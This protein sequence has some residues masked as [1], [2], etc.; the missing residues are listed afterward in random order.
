MP[1]PGQ[2]LVETRDEYGPIIVHQSGELRYLSF[3]GKVE[4]S[5]SY[6]SAPYRLRH[7]YTQ[8]MMLALAFQPQAQRI[9]ALGLGAGSLCNACLHVNPTVN[10]D[11][12][13][14]RQA[15]IDLAREEFGLS[16]DPR[17]RCYCA[18]AKHWLESSTRRYSCALIDLYDRDGMSPLQAD[19]TFLDACK[20]HLK[21]DG[22]AVFNLWGEGLSEPHSEQAHSEQDCEP[23]SAIRAIRE[24]FAGQILELRIAGGN[25]CVFA[26]A[27]TIPEPRRRAWMER[28]EAIGKRLQIPLARHA[29][30]LWSQNGIRG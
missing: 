20:N 19:P 3:D 6:T 23:V 4:Q 13:E 15:I 11:A 27:G 14:L 7:V 12:I 26:F 28:C 29:R 18:D 22:L 5:C 1:L 16:T 17:L 9:L 10:I 25:R 24:C 30:A 8:A 2:R 21:A